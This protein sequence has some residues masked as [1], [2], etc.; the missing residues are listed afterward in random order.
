[1]FFFLI[2]VDTKQVKN[3]QVHHQITLEQWQHQRRG[4]WLLQSLEKVLIGSFFLIHLI[5]VV[6]ALTFPYPEKYL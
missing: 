2:S 1:M 3:P 6:L 4:W 5:V